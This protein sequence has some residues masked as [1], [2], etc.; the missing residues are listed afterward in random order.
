MSG[1]EP[2]RIEARVESGFIVTGTLPNCPAPRSYASVPTV[3]GRCWMRVPP[4]VTFSNCMPR[5]M[6]SSGKCASSAAAMTSCSHSSRPVRG[7]PVGPRGPRH[8]LLFPLITIGARGA[9]ALVR[10]LAVSGWVNVGTTGDDE[11]VE[12]SEH[13][14]GDVRGDRLRRQQD[15]DATAGGPPVEVHLRQE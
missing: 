15:R 5:Q 2:C 11:S 10:T 8:E 4:S 13:R 9:R 6:P 12:G 3:S 14:A 1:S 7:G